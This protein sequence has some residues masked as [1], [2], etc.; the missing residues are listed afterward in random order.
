MINNDFFLDIN[1]NQT[2]DV[3]PTNAIIEPDLYEQWLVAAPFVLSIVI[4]TIMLLSLFGYYKYSMSKL[5]ADECPG[6]VTL[7]LFIIINYFRNLT[8]DLLGESFEKTTPLFIA[9]FFY[10]LTSNLIGMIALAPPTASITVTV[11]LGLVTW[12][13]TQVIGIRYQKW[14]YLKSMFVTITIKTKDGN[15][16]RIPIIPNPIEILGKITPLISISFRLWGN[17]FAG[18]LIVSLIYNIPF[19]FQGTEIFGGLISEELVIDSPLVVIASL[20]TPP[21]HLYLDV[22]TGSIQA[23]VFVILT[24]VYWTMEKNEN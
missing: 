17:I 14:N 1:N 6:G 24:M 20:F 23:F 12:I 4:V 19:I 13:G 8:R 22:M 7:V 15:K 16:T 3:S 9:L 18:V 21:V 2:K 11:S 5:H 10:I